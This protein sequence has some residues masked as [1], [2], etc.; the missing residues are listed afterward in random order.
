MQ[1]RRA[2]SELRMEGSLEVGGSGE[3]R[4]RKSCV[5]QGA[6]SLLEETRVDRVKA[7]AGKGSCGDRKIG[8][9]R[10]LPTLPTPSTK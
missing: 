2:A 3:R 8:C 9:I 7:P 5:A 4:A 1:R 10:S 6:Y